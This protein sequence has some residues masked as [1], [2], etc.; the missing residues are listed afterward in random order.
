M[1]TFGVD[2]ASQPG[3]TAIC[4]IE[5]RE[6]RAVIVELARGVDR[7]GEKLRDERLLR[8]IAGDAY[9]APPAMTAIDAPLGWPT[10]FAQVIADQ[11]AWPDQLEQ[12]P[13]N[14]LRRAT[15]LEVAKRTGKQ[16][17]AVTTERIAYAA[18]RASRIL[19]RLERA[20]ALTVDRS[21][22][23]GAICETYPDAALREFGLWPPGLDVRASYKHK[24]DPTVR[25]QIVDGLLRRAP[26]LKLDASDVALLHA[27]DDCLDA[28]LCALVARA[29]FKGRTIRP[30]NPT[31]AC[32]EGWIHLPEGTDTFDG[33]LA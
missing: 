5:W 3:G 7:F 27:S 28:M 29:C 11:S 9:G 16:P 19:G 10:L 24:S 15:D 22:L 6:E 32:V 26:W 30:T 2:L 1:R 18:M 31:L 12:N 25:I 17:L 33:L 14:L 8:A 21:G 20:T 13:P 4:L 23:T